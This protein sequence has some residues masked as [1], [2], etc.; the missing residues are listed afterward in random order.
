MTYLTFKMTADV[1]ENETV[2]VAVLK[3]I[4]IAPE[5][6]SLAFLEASRNL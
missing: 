6:V 5:M 4:Y 1:V 2:E 3:H